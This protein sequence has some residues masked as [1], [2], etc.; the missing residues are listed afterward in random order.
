MAFELDQ[1]QSQV[2][3][4][5]EFKTR[6]EAALEEAKAALVKKDNMAEYYDRRR[7]PALEYQPGDRVFLDVSDIHTTRPSRKLSH[8]RLGPFPIVK[9]VGNNAYHLHLPPSMSRLHLVFNVVKLTLALE[10][11]IPGQCPRPP[12]KRT[13]FLTIVSRKSLNTDSEHTL[14]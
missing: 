12:C 7:T 9:K 13:Q 2:E 3:S 14:L 5:N 6:T 8:Q 4:M 11:P 10:D 1:R